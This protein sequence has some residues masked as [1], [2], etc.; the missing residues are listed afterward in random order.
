[1]VNRQV[2]WADCNDEVLALEL[3]ELAAADFD[4]S[5]TGFDPKEL[6]DPEGVARLGEGQPWLLVTAPH[7]ASRW[8]RNGGSGWTERVRAC[9]GPAT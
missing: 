1:M 9:L 6:D 7:T 3:Q 5:L 2:T 4:L 8:T